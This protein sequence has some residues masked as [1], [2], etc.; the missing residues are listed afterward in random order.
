MNALRF[1]VC[2]PPVGYYA[3]G[4][5]PNQTRRRRYVEWKRLVAVELW[6]QCGIRVPLLARKEHPLVVR[7]VTWF[8]NG[9][10]ADPENVHKGVKDA[11]FYNAKGGDKYTGGSYDPPRYDP[12]NPRVDVF[13]TC[14]D[15]TEETTR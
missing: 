12:T 9:R 6:Q 3:E 8:R 10:H 2:G 5:A 14:G 4:K 7:T 1:T 15:I 11:L 13:V